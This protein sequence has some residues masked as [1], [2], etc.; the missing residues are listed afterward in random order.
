MFKKAIVFNQPIGD[1]DVSSV[2][3]MEEMFHTASA[4]NQDLG[5]WHLALVTDMGTKPAQVNMFI[6]SPIPL[7][8][9][10]DGDGSVCYAAPNIPV[11]IAAALVAAISL[12][13]LWKR[14]TAYANQCSK[15]SSTMRS[16]SAAKLQL[17]MWGP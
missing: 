7:R 16:S 2:T 5:C 15:P 12:Y 6:G 9:K 10:P 11:I 13:V 17:S 8:Y 1:W 3:G 14:Q 4:F